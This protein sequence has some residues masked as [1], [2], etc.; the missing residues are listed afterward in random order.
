MSA[1]SQRLPQR[2]ISSCSIPRFFGFANSRVSFLSNHQFAVLPRRQIRALSV[3]SAETHLEISLPE[4]GLISDEEHSDF[5][6]VPVNLPLEKLFV[7]PEVELEGGVASIRVLKGS[8]IV[9]GPHA[10]GELIS[11][12]EFVK[13]ST[14]TEDCPS[15]N[16]P[17]FALVG[18][19]NVGKSS[20]LNS[21][22]R[23]KRLALTSK[24]PGL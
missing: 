17:E 24:K 6:E 7:P 23:R 5:D 2:I 11:S 8:N 1:L 3:V 16:R 19:S 20:L 12:A 13:S 14:K 9:L 22:V 10:K 15:D 21:I 18:R 4:T